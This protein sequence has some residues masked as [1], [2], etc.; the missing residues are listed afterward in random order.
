LVVKQA[1]EL[2]FKGGFIIMDQ[3]KMDEMAR[4]LGGYGPL[5]GSIGTMPLVADSR[6]GAQAFVERFR[7]AYGADKDPTSEM[8]LNYTATWVIA[9]AMKLA[10]TTS[11]PAKIRAQADKA[12]AS[13]SKEHNPNEIEGVAENGAFKADVVVGVVEDGKIRQVRLSELMKD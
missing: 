4:V 2:G 10:G 3:A 13:L 12:A 1:R 5:E 6:P 11:D 8:S 7:K 9:D